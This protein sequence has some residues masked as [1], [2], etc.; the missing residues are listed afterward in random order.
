MPACVI[1]VSHSSLRRHRIGAR[2]LYLAAVLFAIPFL[3]AAD[4][5]TSTNFMVDSPLINAAGGGF[6]TST[7]FQL[8]SS[9]AQPAIGTST[10]TNFTAQAGFL[11]FATTAASSASTPSSPT[12]PADPGGGGPIIQTPT[13]PPA[14][15]PPSKF[16]PVPLAALLSF[17][18][19]SK[20]DVPGCSRSDL[21]C[22]G[23]VN[24]QDLSILLT[25]P[26]APTSKSLSFLFSDWTETLPV[27]FFTGFAPTPAPG[28][29]LA[30][31]P[32]S[33]LAQISEVTT[34][35]TAPAAG[36]A[37]LPS[38]FKQIVAVLVAIAKTIWIMLKAL[39]AAFLRIF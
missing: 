9:F 35:T 34:A 16:Q 22:D 33:G 14:A 23:T 17:L 28:P 11:Y 2:A 6:A 1:A 29:T 37:N 21:N 27:P 15:V 32:V 24:L 30:R 19:G 3:A 38:L 31:Q 8:W 7:N 13:P 39:G 18:I 20:V 12:T 4:S 5:I 10:A 26:Q 25:A 36:S